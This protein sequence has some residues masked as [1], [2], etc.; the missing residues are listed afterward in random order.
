MNWRIKDKGARISWN[1]EEG[2]KPFANGVQLLQS[3]NRQYQWKQYKEKFEFVR[4]PVLVVGKKGNRSGRMENVKW[5]RQLNK[6]VL[7]TSLQFTKGMDQN[8]IH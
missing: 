7:W 4:V 3:I 5:V 2:S 6:A 8:I 1:T